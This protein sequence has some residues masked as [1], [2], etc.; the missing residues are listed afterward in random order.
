MRWFTFRY[1][2][3]EIETLT[4]KPPYSRQYDEMSITSTN[5]ILMENM[6]VISISGFIFLVFLLSLLRC[7]T[8]SAY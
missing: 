7:L 5:F 1:E 8:T 6:F 3:F 4:Q 2:V